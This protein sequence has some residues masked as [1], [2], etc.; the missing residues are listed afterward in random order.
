MAPFTLLGV[1]A[2][3]AGGLLAA[4]ISGRPI[5]V[6]V[7]LVA[8]LVLVV[9]VAQFALGWGQA[10]LAARLPPY[11]VA[12]EWLIF[13]LGNA[14]TVAGTLAGLYRMTIAGSILVAIAMP[15]FTWGLIGS[16][17]HPLWQIPYYALAALI[18]ASAIAGI[19]LA[20]HQPDL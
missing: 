13:N 12:L 14:G 9:G 18:F 17:R 15:L 1:M 19:I 16:R 3:V 5:P 4:R 11:L 7:W 10:R 2:I 20:A 6:L 8:Y